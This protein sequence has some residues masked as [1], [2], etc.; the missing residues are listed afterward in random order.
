MSEASQI[1]HGT[2]GPNRKPRSLCRG[3]RDVH[4]QV[5]H[6]LGFLTEPTDE[7]WNTKRSRIILTKEVDFDSRHQAATNT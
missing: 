2:E 1:C 3:M 4:L 7:A 5:F 6:G